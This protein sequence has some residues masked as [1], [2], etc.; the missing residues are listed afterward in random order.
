MKTLKLITLVCSI[1]FY[2]TA[3]SQN[4]AGVKGG[5]NLSNIFN[6]NINDQNMRVGYHAGLFFKLVM[7]DFLAIQPEFLYTTKGS[8]A[9]Y[10]NFLTG[11]GE[12]TQEFNYLEVP[13]LGVINLSDN[14]NIHAGPY[15]AYLLSAKVENKSADA[16]FNF[17]EDLDEDDFERIDFGIAAGIGF[18]FDIFRFGIRYDYGMKKIGKNQQFS[19]NGSEMSSNNFK[20]SRNSSTSLYIGLNF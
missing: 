6:E 4:E 7:T 17:V 1:F 2:S 14:L 3:F 13:I 9:E 19:L 11:K 5:L 10:N 8:T 20:N 18:E 16:S 15:F 12:F